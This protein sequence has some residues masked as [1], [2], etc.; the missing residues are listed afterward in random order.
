MMIKVFRT[1]T[2]STHGKLIKDTD[3][4]LQVCSSK[5]K[6]NFVL[7]NMYGTVAL[8]LSIGIFSDLQLLDA[9]MGSWCFCRGI[10]ASFLWINQVWIYLGSPEPTKS[11]LDPNMKHE[12]CVLVSHLS[13]G[14]TWEFICVCDRSPVLVRQTIGMEFLFVSSHYSACSS[15]STLKGSTTC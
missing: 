7:F 9:R 14:H 5:S 11:P 1:R 4:W 3:A 12:M 10:K 2:R 15:Y 8:R 6:K 13:Y